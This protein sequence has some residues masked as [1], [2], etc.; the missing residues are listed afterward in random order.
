MSDSQPPRMNNL[1]VI[2]VSCPARHDVSSLTVPSTMAP[3]GYPVRAT[4]SRRR[5]AARARADNADRTPRGTREG[6][7]HRPLEA[8]QWPSLRSAEANAP[9][10][11]CGSST[12]TKSR[13]IWPAEDLR[14]EGNSESSSTFADVV[15]RRHATQ[16]SLQRYARFRQ[17]GARY[18][19]SKVP[20]HLHPSA[21]RA[22][23]RS[24]RRCS[25]GLCEAYP[26]ITRWSPGFS[27]RSMMPWRSS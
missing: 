22:T 16:A 12:S 15:P 2:E 1:T 19:Y 13:V 4:R 10:R 24:F 11:W 27:V 5:C 18:D 26:V 23:V 8:W 17:R 20:A 14:Q 6:V 3:P 21:G 25:A 7:S 9:P